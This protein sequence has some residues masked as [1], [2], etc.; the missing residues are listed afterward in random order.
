MDIL[1]AIRRRASTRAFLDKPVDRTTIEKIL[2]T[3]R[4]AP[5]GADIQPWHVA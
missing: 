5:S 1:E 2:D 3:A 4:W